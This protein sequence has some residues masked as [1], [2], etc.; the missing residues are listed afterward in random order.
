MFSGGLLVRS[1]QSQEVIHIV[2]S[3]IAKDGCTETLGFSN[4][5]T[6]RI[7]SSS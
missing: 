1:L 2:Q 7:R 3:G 6:P 4:R 5:G